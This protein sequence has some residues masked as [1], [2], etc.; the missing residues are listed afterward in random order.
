MK[1]WKWKS[2]D[3]SGWDQSTAA[4]QV[5]AAQVASWCLWSQWAC[6][7]ASSASWSPDSSLRVSPGRYHHHV[8]D[9]FSLL[10]PLLADCSS[11]PSQSSPGPTAEKWNHLVSQA[12]LALRKKIR[13]PVPSHRSHGENSS[14]SKATSTPKPPPLAFL[15]GPSPAVHIHTTVECLILQC[16][17][18]FPVSLLHFDELCTSL[19]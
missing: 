8:G 3:T 18:F 9:L 6:S 10:L 12:C 16:R 7:G 1:D 5:L 14:R 19:I 11:G 2:L 4:G 13:S 17:I 15:L